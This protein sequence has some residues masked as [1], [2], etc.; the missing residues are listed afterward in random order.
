[1]IAVMRRS[2]AGRADCSEGELPDMRRRDW[3]HTEVSRG[4]SAEVRRPHE[5]RG[6]KEYDGNEKHEY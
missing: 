6:G 3:F 4:V 1:M 5:Q 2:T